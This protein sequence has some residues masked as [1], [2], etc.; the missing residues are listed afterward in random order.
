MLFL[1]IAY[2]Y[3]LK[4]YT[5]N[6]FH[7]RSWLRP[8]TMSSFMAGVLLGS[9]VLGSLSDKIGNNDKI[10]NIIVYYCTWFNG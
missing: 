7:C 4:Y 2:Q 9:L 6:N 3:I 5:C 8:A 1:K 10:Q